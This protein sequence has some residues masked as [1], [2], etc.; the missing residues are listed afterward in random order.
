ML[1][2]RRYR[3]HD[4]EAEDRQHAQQPTQRA[5][6]RC[7]RE[8]LFR[9]LHREALG[10]QARRYGHGNGALILD[11]ENPALVGAHAGASA[12]RVMSSSLGTVRADRPHGM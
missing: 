12:V 2:V 4:D 6:D 5:V 10:P 7:G 1:P 9:E 11:Y 3:S 8:P